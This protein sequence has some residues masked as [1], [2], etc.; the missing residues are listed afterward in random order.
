MGD[1]RKRKLAKR[2]ESAMKG[3]L[4]RDTNGNEPVEKVRKRERERQES[5]KYT[6]I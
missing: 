1:N 3:K 4:D 2:G 5:G 6:F